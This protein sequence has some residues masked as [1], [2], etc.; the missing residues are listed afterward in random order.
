MS[1]V[2]ALFVVWS[3]GFALD[4]VSSLVANKS[5]Y[6]SGIYNGILPVLHASCG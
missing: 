3:L 2:E 4:E 5:A 1:P 6:F